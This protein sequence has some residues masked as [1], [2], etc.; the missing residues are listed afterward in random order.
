VVH[1]NSSVLV[2][3]AV[4]E[5]TASLALPQ[6]YSSDIFQFIPLKV[7]VTLCRWKH[8]V[9]P[10]NW[11]AAIFAPAI[12]PPPSSQIMIVPRTL[13]NLDNSDTRRDVVLTINRRKAL[14]P[15]PSANSQQRPPSLSLNADGVKWPV[16]QQSESESPSKLLLRPPPSPSSISIIRPPSR[17]GAMK[18]DYR[19]PLLTIPSPLLT[20]PSQNIIATVPEIVTGVFNP[21]TTP[22]LVVKCSLPLLIP[23]PLSRVERASIDSVLTHKSSQP[24]TNRVK[25]PSLLP[26]VAA[27]AAVVKFNRSKS[28]SKNKTA[29]P[30]IEPTKHINPN[31]ILSASM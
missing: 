14:T 5:M 19:R 22:P 4:E 9:E 27:A 2:V 23:L 10:K 13:S 1:I 16:P 15:P 17:N 30:S 25:P 24:S 31:I 18:S 8:K 11:A 12:K 20:I 26:S 29:P 3:H 21:S 6:G 28:R 7:L